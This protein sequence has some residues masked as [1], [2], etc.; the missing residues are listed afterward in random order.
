LAGF[1]LV[2]IA[3][4]WALAGSACGSDPLSPVSH[5]G[6]DAGAGD[7]EVDAGPP[8]PDAA[9]CTS[10]RRLEY[11][12]PTSAP[13][14]IGGWDG[15]GAQLNQNVYAPISAAVG[16]TSD[17]V[18]AMEDKLVAL[19][20]QVVRIFFDS[21][22]F[23]DTDLMASFVRTVQLAERS[24]TA[25]NIT[26]WHGPYPDPTGQMMQFSNVLADLVT[27]RSLSTVRYVT[28]QN[29]VNSTTITQ[30]TYEQLYRLLD[31]D[32]RTA[33]IRDRIQLMGGDLLGQTSPLGQS[34][35]SWFNYMA[36]HMADVLDA[37]SIHV[38]WNYW[39]TAHMTTRLNDVKTVVGGLPESGR[40]PVYV[41]EF[42][43]RGMPKSGVLD[44]GVYSNGTPIEQTNINGGQHL[45]ATLLAAN[46][47]YQG[48]SKW[49]AYVAK[50][51]SGSQDY[52]T[53]GPPGSGWP[54]RPVYYAM[55]LLTSTVVPGS[56]VVRV[57][58]STAGKTVSA[59]LGPVGQWTVVLLNH[60]GSSQS[61]TLSGLPPTTPLYV[62]AWNGGGGGKL[63]AHEKVTTGEDC[64][65]KLTLP[66]DSAFAVSTD[67]PSPAPH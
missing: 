34:E 16:V 15:L 52:A 17:N 13:T 36:T 28:I 43:V 42:G 11:H 39:D 65:T 10:T 1:R 40:K 29:E 19:G 14:F 48:L 60:S 57:Q 61:F 58:G 53:I 20:P 63:A 5:D 12:I 38:Y 41:M 37:Y 33:G 49:D 30:S 2:L 46:L 25:T 26:Y 32:L 3:L 24:G 35:A 4:G 27:T 44:P 21:R 6:G 64:T 9:I 23:G 31:G 54:L 18:G 66:D 47:G 56:R 62:T 50:Y 59:F 8:R 67:P 45:W 55:R 7:G 22:A 51:D